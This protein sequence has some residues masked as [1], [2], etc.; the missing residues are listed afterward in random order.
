M[1]KVFHQLLRRLILQAITINFR[2]FESLK[3]RFHD[4]SEL[5]TNEL[6][7]CQ[8]ILTLRL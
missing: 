6:V 3:K 8:L 1:L 7:F 4:F 2:R 5:I